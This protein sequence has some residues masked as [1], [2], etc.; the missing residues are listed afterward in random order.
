MLYILL[1]SYIQKICQLANLK[2]ENQYQC[3]IY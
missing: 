3:F 2:I 1:S